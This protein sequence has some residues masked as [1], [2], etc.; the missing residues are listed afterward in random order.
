MRAGARIDGMLI[1][2]GLQDAELQKHLHLHGLLRDGREAPGVVG[3]HAQAGVEVVALPGDDEIAQL[4][5]DAVAVGR[6]PGVRVP[7]GGAW[8]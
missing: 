5:R 1:Y 8:T 3:V 6:L 7:G 2:H 4:G